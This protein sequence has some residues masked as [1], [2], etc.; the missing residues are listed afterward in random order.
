MYALLQIY[1]EW[2]REYFLPV[3][4][5]DSDDENTENSDI[6]TARTHGNSGKKPHDL[7]SF[8]EIKIVMQLN[9]IYS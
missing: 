7:L 3:Q 6:S 4:N 9:K 1:D 2:H 5:F 8:E